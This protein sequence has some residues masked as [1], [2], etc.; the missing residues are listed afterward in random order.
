MNCFKAMMVGL[1][2][3]QTQI[4]T[5]FATLLLLSK[6]L[7][8]RKMNHFQ[9]RSLKLKNPWLKLA[10]RVPDESVL[11]VRTFIDHRVRNMIAALSLLRFAEG[12]ATQ[13]VE[14]VFLASF[15]ESRE[16]VIPSLALE[17]YMRTIISHAN[18]P[19]IP[20]YLSDATHAIFNVV[21]PDHHLKIGWTIL[22][23]F[24]D[25]FDKLSV[26]WRRTFAEGFFSLSRQPLSRSQGG[27][28][29]TTQKSE[30][31]EILTWEYFHK[32]KQESQFTDFDFS[33]LDWMAMA[34]SLLIT[35]KRDNTGRFNGGTWRSTVSG[36][37]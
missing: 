26:E 20:C 35:T 17:Y 27:V 14:S 34:W 11:D 6:S 13:S 2:P 9:N 30:L 22:E 16:F 29:T 21:L 19:S 10:A 15:L 28:E 23:I 7:P 8:S 24:V 37:R 4:Q 12:T 18:P 36:F 25:G 32:E 5:F 31:E 3:G 1:E 33:G